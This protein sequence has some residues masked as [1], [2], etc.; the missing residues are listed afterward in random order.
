[1]CYNSTLLQAEHFWLEN[2]RDAQPVKFM[3]IFKIHKSLK[4]KTLYNFWAFQIRGPQPLLVI[5]VHLIVPN[6][7]IVFYMCVC[8]CMSK[9]IINVG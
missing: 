1:M 4:F 5:I 3:Q 7:E 9:N 2:H 8:V 6:L